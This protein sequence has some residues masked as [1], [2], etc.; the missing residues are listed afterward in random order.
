[1]TGLRA[2]RRLLASAFSDPVNVSPIPTVII[3]QV[4]ENAFLQMPLVAAH[5]SRVRHGTHVPRETE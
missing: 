2:I 1:M 5:G 3:H 4:S